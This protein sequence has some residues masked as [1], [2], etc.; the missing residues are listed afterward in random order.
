MKYHTIKLLK[1]LS[2][3]LDD[4]AKADRTMYLF[5]TH[6]DEFYA[7]IDMDTASDAADTDIAGSTIT[8]HWG[9]ADAL[10]AVLYTVHL[11]LDRPASFSALLLFA[12]IFLAS[13][14]TFLLPGFELDVTSALLIA[15]TWGVL[16]VLAVAMFRLLPRVDASYTTRRDMEARMRSVVERSRRKRGKR[17]VTKL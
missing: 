9:I 1:A 2:D 4:Q 14:A 11:R 7:E 13:L 12:A 3:T 10:K 15:G 17:D 16:A 5:Q 6:S 8:K